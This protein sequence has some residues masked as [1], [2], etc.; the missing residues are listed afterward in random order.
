MNTKSFINRL[1]FL[2]IFLSII[3]FS[4]AQDTTLHATFRVMTIPSQFV[5]LDFPLIIEKIVKR[6]SIGILLSYRPSTQNSGEIRGSGSGMYGDYI[7]ETFQNKLNNGVTIGV[8][9]KYYMPQWYNLFFEGDLFYRYWWFENKDCYYN[10]VEGYR[11]DGIRTESQN[12][13]G[14]KLL[15]GRSFELKSNAKVKFLLDIYG[16]VGIRYRTYVYETVDGTVNDQYYSYL[17]ET[18]TNITP[19]LQLGIKVGIGI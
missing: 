3:R 10:N 12:V 11:F 6:H 9:T 14:L 17:R 19:S 18:G 15:I 5:V 8:S 2:I 7:Y 4:H 16:G 13:Y 1:F